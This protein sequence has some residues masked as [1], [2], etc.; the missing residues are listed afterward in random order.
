MCVFTRWIP[1]GKAWPLLAFWA[2]SAALPFPGWLSGAVPPLPTQTGEEKPLR[3]VELLIVDERAGKITVGLHVVLAPG[4]YIYWLNPGDAG[5]APE[6]RWELPA[7]F[8]A[9]KLLFPAPQRFV[10]GDIVTYGYFDETLILCAIRRPETPAPLD[11]VRIGAVLDWM[12]CR[13]SCVT[14]EATAQVSL[15]RPSSELLGQSRPVFTR[16]ASRYPRTGPAPDLPSLEARLSKLS[17]RWSVVVSFAGPKAANATDFYPYP[18]EDFVVDHH[19][20][21]VSAGKIAIPVQPSRPEAVLRALGGLL[22]IGQT[23]FEVSI[24]IKE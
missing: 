22:I 8:T 1:A 24:P 2:L 12:A 21:A 23:A 7:G 3:R 11:K 10:H 17:G 14:G 20:I 5:L 19:G 15:S 16:F 13:E 6:V 4:W 18:V 9:G